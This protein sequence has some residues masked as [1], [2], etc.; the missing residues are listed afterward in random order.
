MLE[1]GK[2]R[3]EIAE[4]LGIGRN[5]LAGAVW[6]LRLRQKGNLPAKRKP[7]AMTKSPPIQ[8]KEPK[9]PKGVPLVDARQ[10]QCRSIV[11][12][13]D[14]LALFCGERTVANTSWCDHHIRLYYTRGRINA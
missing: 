11:G 3:K 6:R 4:I 2:S 14:G 1:E 7:P 13:W 5:Q 12:K 8:P 10:D 9:P